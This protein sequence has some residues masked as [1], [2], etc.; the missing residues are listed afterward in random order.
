MHKN[1]D[2]KQKYEKIWKRNKDRKEE[3]MEQKREESD[4]E[5]MKKVKWKG[6]IFDTQQKRIG[7]K[8]EVIQTKEGSG[9]E[10]R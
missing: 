10:K 8:R 1:K 6:K 4:I 2:I 9:I 3:N 7:Y 5:T